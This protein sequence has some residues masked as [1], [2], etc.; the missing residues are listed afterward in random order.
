MEKSNTS[1]G[2]MV[3]QKAHLLVLAIYK[4]TKNFPKKEIYALTRQ[5]RRASVSIA[6]NIADGCK[7]KTIPNKLNFL[8]ILEGSLK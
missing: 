4:V 2:L 1:K 3:L 6:A 5:V 8:N 7:K